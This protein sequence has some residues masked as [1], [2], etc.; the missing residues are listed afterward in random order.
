M[1][2]ADAFS[3]EDR[4]MVTFTDFY[5]LM[6]QSAERDIIMNGINCDVPHRHLRQMITGTK[7]E[8]GAILLEEDVAAL[9]GGTL[10]IV[11]EE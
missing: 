8:P 11:N 7:E 10:C 3:K 5:N 1:G 2:L 4:V 9:K 6:R